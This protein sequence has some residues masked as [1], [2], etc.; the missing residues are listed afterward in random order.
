MT[1]PLQKKIVLEPPNEQVTDEDH[2]EEELL[3]EVT[4][5]GLVIEV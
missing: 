4:A 5:A 3:E 2:D 1:D